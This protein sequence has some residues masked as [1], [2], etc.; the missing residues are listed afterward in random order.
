MNFLGIDIYTYYIIAYYTPL[1]RLTDLNRFLRA[2]SIVD[3]FISYLVRMY[4][5]PKIKHIFDF[6]LILYFIF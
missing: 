4:N 2:F 6:T 5:M 3:N 1:L